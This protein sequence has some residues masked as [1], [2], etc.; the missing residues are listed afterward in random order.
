MSQKPAKTKPSVA[1]RQHK[2]EP[3]SLNARANW[4]WS[5][6][7]LTYAGLIVLTSLV[8]IRVAQNG[9]INYDD[10]IYITENSH[11]R[12]GLTWKTASWAFK[13]IDEANWHPLTWLS[14]SLDYQLFGASAGGHHLVS[15]ALHIANVVLLFGLLSNATR[16]TGRSFLVAVLFAIHPL[17]VESV[18][19][20][21]ERKNVLC[22]LFFLLT[23]A[24]YGRYARNPE[25]KRYL[26]VTVLFALALASKPMAVTLPC[27]LLLLDVWPLHRIGRAGE[28]QNSAKSRRPQAGLWSF[29]GVSPS[30]A[31]VEKIPLFAMT[32]A[33]CIITF[34][35]QRYGGA[36]LPSATELPVGLRIENAVLAYA[37]YIWKAFLPTG[38]APMYPH[39]GNAIAFWQVALSIVFLAAVSVW[40][41]KR[42]KTAPYLLV[43]WLWFLGSLVPVIGI[44]QVGK[45]AMAD[46]YGYIPLIGI[47]VMSVWGIADLADQLSLSFRWRA[48]IAGMMLATLSFLTW[49][50]IGF[51]QDSYA[52]WTHTLAVTA[53]NKV[54]ETNLSGALVEGG[55]LDEAI[56]HFENILR[57]DPQD[58]TSYANIGAELQ[59]QGK[60][61]DAIAAYELALMANPKPSLRAG[62]YVNLWTIYTKLE[63]FPLAEQSFEQALAIEP[64][65]PAQLIPTFLQSVNTHP[66]S[67]NFLQ[68]GQL[69]QQSGDLSDARAAYQ[70][71][72]Q[73]D[74]DFAE[75]RAMLAK[76]GSPPK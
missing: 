70:R 4:L 27:L 46:R 1:P 12:A 68:L 23:I 72:L 15:L 49:R 42:R 43:G 55:R 73:I 40:T 60:Q 16:Q 11:I 37:M 41:W 44:V 47:F 13:S 58:A 52:L 50:Q 62:V 6:T 24:A 66:T 34:Y 71:S 30:R 39:P 45:Q 5:S 26:L 32:I 33:S 48:A 51:W 76:L 61:H 75:A 20:A 69:L 54:A 65:F 31:M 9:F 25:V 3:E 8:W 7:V 19:W 2:L 59:K 10:G 56:P 28:T 21:A 63:N 57:M 74:P 17:N 22:T 14:H 38:L 36:V 64:S 53:N 29:P 67:Q 18:A 35:A